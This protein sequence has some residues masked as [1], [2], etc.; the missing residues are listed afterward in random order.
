MTD[1]KRKL[2][3][4]SSP[5]SLYGEI[6]DSDYLEVLTELYEQLKY[7]QERI[8]QLEEN[9]HRTALNRSVGGLP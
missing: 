8:V 7:A 3:S 2:N 4:M 5:N 1:L 9:Q 6:S